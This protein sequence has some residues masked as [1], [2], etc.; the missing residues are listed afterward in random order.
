MAGKKVRDLDSVPSL[1]DDDYFLTALADPETTNKIKKVDALIGAGQ[2]FARVVKKVDETIINDTTLHDDAELFVALNSNKVYAFQ[3]LINFLSTTS[4]NIKFDMSIP[5][6][7]TGEKTDGNLTSRNSEFLD[8][9]T[10][11][12]T[13]LG[14]GLSAAYVMMTG[15]IKTS[16]VAGDFT[17]EWAQD[18]LETNSTAV[19]AG[20]YLIVWEELP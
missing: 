20:S 6:G 3:V 19:L 9:I 2:T 17:I 16:G 15:F 4:A 11:S 12:K 10:I 1:A 5:T 13:Y 14:Q 8:V 18:V 7:A